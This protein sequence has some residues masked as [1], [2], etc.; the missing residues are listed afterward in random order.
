MVE[1][2]ELAAHRTSKRILLRQSTR[3][4]ARLMAEASDGSSRSRSKRILIHGRQGVG[5]TA[6]L[7]ALVASARRSGC[8]VLYVPDVD[9]LR[10][11]GFYVEPSPREPGLFDLPVLSQQ[12][13]QQLLKSHEA[14]MSALAVPPGVVEEHLTADQLKQLDEAGGTDVSLVRVLKAGASKSSLAPAC[15]SVAMAVLMEQ[16]KVPF[17]M[18]VDELNCFYEPSL[19]FH[20]DYDVDVKKPIPY[21]QIS[22]F[23]PLL[24]AVQV[25]RSSDP[26]GGDEEEA[27][28]RKEEE[29]AAPAAIRRGG[30]V[31]ATSES[32]GVSRKV[33]DGLV[34]SARLQQAVRAGSGAAPIHLVEVPPL[35]ALEVEHVVANYEA[36][37]IG[38]LR[39]DQGETVMNEQEVAYL[40]IVSGGVAQKLMDACIL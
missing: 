25:P 31:A 21:D 3:E 29:A 8:I 33:T 26:H 15:Y 10:R 6:A 30:V 17:W 11:N 40:R 32:R 20:M 22:L 19:Y 35:S 5:K 28:S 7:A 13:C 24:R 37:G 16:E 12:I 18:A 1:E 23:R 2:W 38:K 14:D 4:A 9:D 39:L 34:E 27:L 36:V